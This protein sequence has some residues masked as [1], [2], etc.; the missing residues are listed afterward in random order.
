MVDL[1]TVSFEPGVVHKATVILQ[2]S[3]L[4]AG[5]K[6]VLPVQE[7]QRSEIE[8]ERR[9]SISIGNLHSGQGI[10]VCPVNDQQSLPAYGQQY[11]APLQKNYYDDMAGLALYPDGYKES[12]VAQEVARVP[13]PIR[14]PVARRPRAAFRAPAAQSTPVTIRAPPELAR[15]VTISGPGMGDSIYAPKPRPIAKT[16]YAPS[17]LPL[18]SESMN[19]DK[20][21]QLE[22]YCFLERVFTDIVTSLPKLMHY[23]ALADFGG[24]EDT[25][26]YLRISFGDLRNLDEIEEHLNKHW[27]TIFNDTM[28]PSVGRKIQQRKLSMYYRVWSNWACGKVGACPKKFELKTWTEEWTVVWKGLWNKANKQG[29]RYG[30]VVE[31]GL[32]PEK[33][34]RWGVALVGLKI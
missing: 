9:P 18:V 21:I 24:D 13:S 11:Q 10:P 17:S 25:L 16:E 29:V 14:I 26:R 33:S 1:L 2:K 15:N 6:Q 12:I 5:S 27:H 23:N 32:A 31:E 22:V 3:A 30:W 34:E 7:Q 20:L 4:E 8:N 28:P 19:A